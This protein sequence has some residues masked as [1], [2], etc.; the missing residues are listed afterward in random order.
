[1]D[2]AV[3]G[4]QLGEDLVPLAGQVQAA[5]G[6]RLDAGDGLLGPIGQQGQSLLEG[7]LG[8]LVPVA[9][10]AGPTLLDAA[11]A[12]IVEGVAPEAGA[13]G[14]VQGVGLAL[15]VVGGVGVGPGAQAEEVEVLLVVGDDHLAVGP[16][17][18]AVGAATG[19]AGE[20]AG[21]GRLLGVLAV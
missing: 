5:Q 2:R 16:V 10:G 20:R 15:G 4:P 8:P 13:D 7:A 14:L 6:L 21:A 11:D 12:Q 19:L 18:Y 17:A 9:P 3:P 1:G